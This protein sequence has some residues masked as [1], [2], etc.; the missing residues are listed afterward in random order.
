MIYVCEIVSVISKTETASYMR[1]LVL[2]TKLII[3]FYFITKLHSSE[4]RE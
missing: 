1:F 4:E 3:L 2:G